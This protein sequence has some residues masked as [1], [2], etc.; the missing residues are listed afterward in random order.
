M[1]LE[2]IESIRKEFWANVPVCG[3]SPGLRDEEEEWLINTPRK[4]QSLEFLNFC[5]C[6][7]SRAA[8]MQYCTYTVG[9]YLQNFILEVIRL[10]RSRARA[11]IELQILRCF[12]T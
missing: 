12:L 7:P 1:L 8:K 9:L 2:L 3:D 5:F 4:I 10:L 6:T 11:K